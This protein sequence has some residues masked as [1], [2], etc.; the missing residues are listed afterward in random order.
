MN[1]SFAIIFPGQGSQ[2]VGMGRELLADDIT[3]NLLFDI[4]S[5][6]S[7]FDLKKICLKG[8]D[9]LLSETSY[10]QPTLTCVCLGLLERF[11]KSGLVPTATAGHSV[12]ELSA[13]A[14]C[15][16]ADVKDI[17]R[18][19]AI[20]GKLMN[21]AAL[22]RL[23]AMAAISDASLEEVQK[24]VHAFQSRNKCLVVAAVNAPFQIVVSGDIESV[25]S[26]CTIGKPQNARAKLLRVSG[27]W[28]SP[29]MEPVVSDLSSQLLK[30]ELLHP[31]FSAFS[32]Y[33]GKPFSSVEEIKKRIPLQLINTVRWDLVIQ[34]MLSA[35]IKDFVEIGPGRV[36]RGLLRLNSS[37]SL[38]VYSVSDLRSIEKTIFELRQFC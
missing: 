30:F 28:H 10:L 23:G 18:I 1:R 26:F 4:A 16:S 2:E 13:L 34:N 20:R 35:G 24:S 15:G 5:E 21:S 17:A 6:E 14:A 25:K 8:P 3:T 12:G 38:N 32:N 9:R 31:K 22:L 33:D 7:G 36:L 11:M 27:A 29:L 19:A 37:S